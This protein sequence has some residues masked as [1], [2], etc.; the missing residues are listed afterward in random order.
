LDYEVVYAL[1]Y[2]LLQRGRYDRA[3]NCFELLVREAPYDSRYWSGLAYV[4]KSLKRYDDA[5][6]AYC[7]LANREEN[8]AQSMLRVAECQL[9]NGAYPGAIAT[10]KMIIDIAGESPAHAEMVLRAR[11]LMALVHHD[12]G[13]A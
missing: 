6:L 3:L 10:L 12:T 13:P 8:S 1:G 9:L 11:A 7:L 4:Y 5:I 2:D